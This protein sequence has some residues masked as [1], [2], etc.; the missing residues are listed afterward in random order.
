MGVVS[1]LVD[2][3]SVWENVMASRREPHAMFAVDASGHL[4]A[5][6]NL[7]V[8]LG[9]DMADS[10]IVKRFKDTTGSVSETMPFQWSPWSSAP[11]ERYLGSYTVSKEGWGIF[12]QANESQVYAPVSEMITNTLA[13]GLLA[14][15]SALLAATVFARVLAQP[16]KRLAEMTRAFSRGNFS[17]RVEIPA[18]IEVAELADRF[19]GMAAELEAHIRRLQEEVAKNKELFFG[20]ARALASA[21]DAKDPYTRGHSD[22][23]NRYSKILARAHG[24]PEPE[25]HLIDIASLLHDVGKIGVDDAI[26]NKPGKLTPEEFELMK[27]HTTIGETIMKPIAQMKPMLPGLKS[28]HERWAGGGYPEGLKGENIP[29]MA[30]I[31][32]VADSFDAMTTDR[33]YQKAMTFEA[34]WKRLNELKG[35]GFDERIVASFNR[36]YEAG[37]FPEPPKEA[38]TKPLRE[39]ANV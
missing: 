5:A 10:E 2:L 11:P 32:A 26:L 31:I 35:T 3:Q 25:I 14:L 20:T 28:H 30:R 12:V 27:K 33:P 6:R 18:I 23:V 13:W 37:E 16:I 29:Q 8:E 4:F 1:A 9:R 34:A 22:R 21:I 19:N 7:E 24:L 39:P 38:G 15:A 36:A 17:A